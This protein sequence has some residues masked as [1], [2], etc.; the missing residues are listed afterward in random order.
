MTVSSLATYGKTVSP[1]HIRHAAHLKV[2]SL[3]IVKTIQCGICIVNRHKGFGKV[4]SDE[5]GRQQ[6]G[7]F[8][9]M[10][11]TAKVGHAEV[12]F[13]GAFQCSTVHAICLQC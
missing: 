9:P 10:H 12:V 7:I 13:L 8:T 5:C 3:C 6:H 1:V 2:L 11:I 4:S